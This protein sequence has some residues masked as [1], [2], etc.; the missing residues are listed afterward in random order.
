MGGG[1]GGGRKGGEGVGSRAS[2]SPIAK[3]GINKGA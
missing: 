1:G 3:P 2:R